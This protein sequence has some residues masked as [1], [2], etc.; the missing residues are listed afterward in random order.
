MF[1]GLGRHTHKISTRNA[2]TQMLFNQG[3]NLSFGFNHAEAIRSFREAARLDPH[4]AMCWWGVAFALGSN[5]NLP[6]PDDAIKPAWQATQNALALKRYASAEE[7]DWID[8]LAERYSSDPTADRG[9]SRCRLCRRDGRVVE[10]VPQGPRRRNLLRRSD[11]GHPTLGLLAD[12][13]RGA[14]KAM[15]ARSSRRW[16]RS[17]SSRRTIPA[18]CTSTSMRSKP[19][20]RRSAR[21]SPPTGWKS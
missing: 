1:K 18:R 7:R 6:M 21:R 5:I 10:E 3:I 4:C 20:P 17:S 11:D 13:R 16:R 12:G 2:R 19:P 9:A 15:A 8:A 14:E